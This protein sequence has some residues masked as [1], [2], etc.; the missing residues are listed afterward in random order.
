[1]DPNILQAEQWARINDSLRFLV[2][3]VGLVI[4][5]TMSFLLAHAIIPSLVTA[6]EAPP[7]TSKLRGILYPISAVSA[8][9]VVWAFATALSGIIPVI[10][11]FYPRFAI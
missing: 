2:L 9:L 11:Y 5:M 3:F 10:Q 8:V 6:G 4:N 7:A 1:M